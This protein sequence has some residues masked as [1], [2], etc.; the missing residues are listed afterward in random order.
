MANAVDGSVIIRTRLDT[1]QLNRDVSAVNATMTGLGNR[2]ARSGTKMSTAW[3]PFKTAAKGITTVLKR[4]GLVA[5]NPFT[6]F[7]KA[8]KSAE[9]NVNSFNDKI[10]SMISTFRSLAAVAAVAMSAVKLANM[11]SDLA[12]VQNVVDVT[13][14]TM[15]DKVNEF[16]Q[17][18]LKAYG[19]SETIAKQFVGTFGAM[20]KGF[21][22]TEQQA[23]D[24]SATL[25]ALTG[26][27][28]SF[29]NIS[30]QEAFTKLKGIFT[31]ETEGLNIRAVA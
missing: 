20:A 22:Y 10:N 2:V 6:L 27:V 3:T 8:E 17:T 11:G 26:D 5:V 18:A 21:G 15:S 13:F 16:A 1:T 9:K 4:V 24:M 23:Y 14:T 31:G 29:Y 28:A 12:E 30:Q 7:R 25:T 19:L